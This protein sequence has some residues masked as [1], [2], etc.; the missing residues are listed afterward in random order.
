LLP[1]AIATINGKGGVGKTSITANVAGLAAAAGYRVLIVDMD[2]QGNLAR[3]VGIRQTGQSDGGK[4]LMDAVLRH[5]PVQ[6]LPNVRPG[7]D[8]VAGGTELEEL[9]DYLHARKSR[10]GPSI[11]Q[12][13]HAAL[14]PVASQYHLILIDTPPGERLL[15]MLALTTAHYAVIPTKSDDGSVDG[16]ERVATLF[17]LAREGDEHTKPVNPGLELLGVVVFGVGTSSR[18]IRRQARNKVAAELG[19]DNL[20]FEAM[21]RHV[22]GPS[23]ECR[24][25]GLLAHE[26]E[27]ATARR[28]RD[29]EDPHSTASGLAT[30][31]QR[32]TSELLERYMGRPAEQAAEAVAGA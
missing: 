8:V 19:D 2:P 4:S 11:Y 13:L 23:K 15:Q 16:L 24:D 32:L 9:A 22:E 30:D 14:E 28:G 10:V 26:L 25:R 7:L 20:V 29:E 21:I 1:Q 12:A 31:Y 5:V 27:A 18:A 6:P 3:D 17:A